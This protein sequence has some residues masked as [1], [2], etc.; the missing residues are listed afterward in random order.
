[1]E[2]PKGNSREDIKARKQIIK[3][4]YAKWIMS[5]PEKRVWNV[6]LKR[7][8]YVKYLSINETVGHASGTYE[9]TAAVLQLTEILKKAKYY[10]KKPKKQYDK[11]Q[12]QFSNIVILMHGSIK[13]T[14]GV[15]KNT[16]DCIQY[17]ITVPGVRMINN[18]SRLG[19]D[20]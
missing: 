9:S 17:C 16:G 2:I 3:D 6:S 1:M 10:E 14:V 11:N 5:N 19:C 13:L 20:F 8:I 7:F 12:K 4:F 18:K 15:H